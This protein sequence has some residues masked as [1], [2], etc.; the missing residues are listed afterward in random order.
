MLP[1]L[2]VI[3][4]T[5]FVIALRGSLLSLYKGLQSLRIHNDDKSQN[6]GNVYRFMAGI[7]FGVA[8]ICL[9]MAITMRTQGLLVYWIALTLFVASMGRIISIKKAGAPGY[10]FHRYALAEI[11]IAVIVCVLQYARTH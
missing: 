7:Y 8:I 3:F 9:W 11:G 6:L 10:K 2:Q 4:V 1:I 5:L